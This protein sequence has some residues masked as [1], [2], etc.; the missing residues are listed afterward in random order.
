MVKHNKNFKSKK[1]QS[2]KKKALRKTKRK[3]GKKSK[4]GGDDFSKHRNYIWDLLLEGQQGFEKNDKGNCIENDLCATALVYGVL[5]LIG[6]AIM[7]ILIGLVAGTLAAYDMTRTE[8]YDA[9]GR[10]IGGRGG[11]IFRDGKALTHVSKNFCQDL[12]DD[13]VYTHKSR[14]MLETHDEIY[15]CNGEGKIKI[16]ESI[17]RTRIN[18]YISRKGLKQGLGY[19]RKFHLLKIIYNLPD[20]YA[21]LIKMMNRGNIT[22]NK[23]NE[24]MNRMIEKSNQQI[25]HVHEEMYKNVVNALKDAVTYYCNNSEDNNLKNVCNPPTTENEITIENIKSIREGMKT[26]IGPTLKEMAT[27]VDKLD[28]DGTLKNDE[29]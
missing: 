13:N 20:T 22:N 12:V 16:L 7:E 26:L 1:K 2:L 10:R 28:I 19:S 24:E 21:K 23:L 9:Y 5:S 3:G 27:Y 4:K 14:G 29:Y 8:T 17:A 6:L 18:R 25:T 15:V 11:S